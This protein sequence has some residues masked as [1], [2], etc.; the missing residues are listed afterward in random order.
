MKP[1]NITCLFVAQESFEANDTQ[2]RILIL[3]GYLSEPTKFH[4][5]HNN[6]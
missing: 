1:I 4:L 2:V 5:S 3:I 6:V